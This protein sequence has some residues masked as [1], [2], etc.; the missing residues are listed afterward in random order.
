MTVTRAVTRDSGSLFKAKTLKFRQKLA[1]LLRRRMRKP[2]SLYLFR[3]LRPP[4][5]AGPGLSPFFAGELSLP[6]SL[7][8]SPSFSR[9]QGQKGYPDSDSTWQTTRIGGSDLRGGGKIPI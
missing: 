2:L 8:G 9:Q 4:G 1:P 3:G 7:Q 6:P 5:A